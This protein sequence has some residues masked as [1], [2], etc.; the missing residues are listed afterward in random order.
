MLGGNVGQGNSA[1]LPRQTTREN[2]VEEL[3][4]TVRHG[5]G[6]SVFAVD[7]AIEAIVE[8]DSP[9][10][11][12]ALAERVRGETAAMR[13]MLRLLEGARPGTGFET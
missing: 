11:R 10:D 9:D 3:L 7:L 4:G 12:K 2:A 6:N 8:S 5:L 13:R 1:T